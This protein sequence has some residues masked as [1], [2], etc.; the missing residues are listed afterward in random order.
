MR[1]ARFRYTPR[2]EVSVE[3]TICAS[4]V[5]PNQALRLRALK[6]TK[7]R[8]GTPRVTGEEWLVDKVGPYYAARIVLRWASGCGVHLVAN[9]SLT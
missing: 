1:C 8:Q 5:R 4:I 3:E 2:V 6:E 9:L 7:D